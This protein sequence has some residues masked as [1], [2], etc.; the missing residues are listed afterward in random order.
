MG[1][2]LLLT[3]ETLNLRVACPALGTVTYGAMLLSATESLL[4]TGVLHQAGIST[5]FINAS[6]SVGAVRVSSTLGF[7]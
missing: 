6:L 1:V 4:A 7:C 3:L 2:V 5:Y